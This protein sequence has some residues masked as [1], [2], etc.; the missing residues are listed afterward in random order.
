L[1]ENLKQIE[2]ILT[3]LNKQ[4]LKVTM[5]L[6]LFSDPQPMVKT[7]WQ[8]S[9]Y[10]QCDSN[11]NLTLGET[12][13][14]LKH[15]EFLQEAGD[16]ATDLAFGPTADNLKSAIAGETHEYTDMYPGMARTAEQEGFTEIAAW[17]RVREIFDFLHSFLFDRQLTLKMITDSRCCWEISRW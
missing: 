8:T 15:L 9:W 14:A 1:L 6:L 4:I 3:L 5:M 7:N 16:P 17:F 12:G 11:P 2:D 13:H 10:Q